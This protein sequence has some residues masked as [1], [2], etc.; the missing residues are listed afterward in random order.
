MTRMPKPVSSWTRR[1]FMSSDHPTAEDIKESIVHN[2]HRRLTGFCFRGEG[3][4]PS[5][6]VLVLRVAEDGYELYFYDED[7][8]GDF[9]NL[10][11]VQYV[12][13]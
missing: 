6:R 2:R 9:F 1:G 10:A 7:P 13:E 4:Y 8:R 12:R 5:H 11:N 3:W